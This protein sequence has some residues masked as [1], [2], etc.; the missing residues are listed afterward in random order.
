METVT[1][2]LLAI[3]GILN[4]SVSSDFTKVLIVSTN[5]IETK[6]LRDVIAHAG[7]YTIQKIKN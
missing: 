5:E 6:T 1:E 7:K 4:V 3:D 2:K